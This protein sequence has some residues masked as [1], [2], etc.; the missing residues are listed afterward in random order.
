MVVLP[1]TEL[2]ACK[3]VAERLRGRISN[4]KLTRRTTG[5]AIGSVT[6]SIGTAQFRAGE[7]AETLIERCDL[8]LYHAKETGRSRVVAEFELKVLSRLE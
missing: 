5:Q 2:G 8:G 4:A 3:E 1:G 7:S 6:V